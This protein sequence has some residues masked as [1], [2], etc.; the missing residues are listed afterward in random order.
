LRIVG[1]ASSSTERL[2]G[3]EQRP[4]KCAYSITSTTLITAWHAHCGFS[5]VHVHC[6]FKCTKSQDAFG[7]VQDATLPFESM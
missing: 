2:P 7:S 6:E 5:S 4:V 3:A 1:E